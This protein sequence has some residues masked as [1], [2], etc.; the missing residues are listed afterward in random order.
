MSFLHYELTV[1]DRQARRHRYEILSQPISLFLYICFC[2]SVSASDCLFL[3]YMS[4]CLSLSVRFYMSVCLSSS[5]AASLCFLSLSLSTFTLFNLSI[6]RCSSSYS[7]TN[8]L[9]HF[10]IFSH[11]LSVFSLSGC[12]YLYL[13]LSNSLSR[14]ALSLWLSLPLPLP[15]CISIYPCHSL[16]LSPPCTGTGTENGQRMKCV[17]H[18]GHIIGGNA[19][20]D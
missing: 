16:S 9:F 4:L 3:F 1:T 12:V 7:S 18:A 11:P 19:D 10:F 15:V 8:P 17:R 13:C 2:I 6:I 5:V 14:L 20:N